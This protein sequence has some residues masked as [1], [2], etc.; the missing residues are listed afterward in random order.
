MYFYQLKVVSGCMFSGKTEDLIREANIAKFNK[1]KT[2]A[3]KAA[4]DDRDPG[5]IQS[6]RSH[7]R[8]ISDVTIIQ[9]GSELEKICAGVK[10]SLILVDEAQFLNDDVIPSVEKI[11]NQGNRV[12]V[13]GLDQLYTGEPFGPMP[14]LLS[15][16]DI[17]K[18]NKAICNIPGCQNSATKTQRLV[19]HAN[20]V[21]PGGL[22]DY[23][24]RCRQ[25]HFNP[26]MYDS[27]SD[28]GWITVVTGCISSGK[29]EELVRHLKYKELSG[30]SVKA[31]KLA[32]GSPEYLETLDGYK[33]PA[34]VINELDEIDQLINQVNVIGIDNV[35][36]IDDTLF[37]K[38]DSWANQGTEIFLAGLDQ[39]YTGKVY[40]TTGN[41]MAIAD[42]VLKLPTLCNQSTCE[43]IAT[44]SLRVN[45]ELYEPRCRLHWKQ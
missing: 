10:G 21:H 5:V 8:S 13:S 36:E 37:Q 14:I 24:P 32:A 31:L 11:V 23:D 22:K 25:H 2:I 33:Y 34:M 16:A 35:H 30:L 17:V 12:V 29:T 42:D 38:C 41:A 40:P 18:K 28:V 43:D 39:D 4:L 7:D 15:L 6:H 45:E 20:P 9:S 1:V 3:V 26:D 27:R 19:E 44:K